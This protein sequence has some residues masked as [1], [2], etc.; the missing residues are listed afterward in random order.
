MSGQPLRISVIIP[1]YNEATTL[2]H[3]L[4]RVHEQAIDGVELEI[5]VIDDGSTDETDAVLRSHAH[6]LDHHIRLERNAG[7]GAAI[8]AGLGAATGAFILCQDADLEYDPSDFQTL[9]RPVLFHGADLVMGSRLSAPPM[10]R[11]HYFWNKVGNRVLTTIFNVLHNTTFSDVYSGYL[12]LKRSAVEP[13]ELR[14]HGWGQQAEI[15][16]LATRRLRTLYE[17]PICYFG[18]SYDE[19][20]KIRAH[21]FFGVVWAM[22]L[23]RL[24]RR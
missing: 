6:L 15:L 7:K 19:G 22:L 4:A 20:K 16:S 14:V 11:V 2:P 21:H 24:L 9:I 3:V 18:R 10:T 13:A 1:A 5:V 12:L 17:V 8:I 23:T